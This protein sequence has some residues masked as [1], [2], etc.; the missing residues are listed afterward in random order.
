MASTTGLSMGSIG[1]HTLTKGVGVPA[2]ALT[3]NG[4]P[5]VIGGFYIII[6]G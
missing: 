6:G 3:I 1:R 2:R 4:A 5:V